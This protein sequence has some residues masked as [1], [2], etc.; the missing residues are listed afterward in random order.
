LRKDY[1]AEAPVRFPAALH[2]VNNFRFD[3]GIKIP[4]REHHLLYREIK[5]KKM[6]HR[7]IIDSVE[8]QVADFAADC[9]GYD[10]RR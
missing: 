1:A 10:V 9:P 8:P 2:K 5:I 4:D 3:Q 7:T 6:R